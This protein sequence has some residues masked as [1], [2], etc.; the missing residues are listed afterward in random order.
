MRKYFWKPRFIKHL[1]I[2]SI[3]T[4]LIYFRNEIYLRYYVRCRLDQDAILKSESR[5][6]RNAPK[7]LEYNSK[8]KCRQNESIYLSQHDDY[9]KV[10]LISTNEITHHRVLFEY[11]IDKTKFEASI[12]TCDMYNSLRRGPHL[13]VLAYS[14]YGKK[15]S[16]YNFINELARLI[17]NYY[18]NWIMR[19]YYDRSIDMSII[20]EI[21][22]LMYDEKSKAEE[23][24]GN[25]V[26]LFLDNVDFCDIENIPYDTSKWWNASY[27]HGACYFYLMLFI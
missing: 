3:P 21:E 12:L 13:K 6:F 11:N 20:C 5:D 24:S 1:L 14:L 18:P 22:C 2:Y 4:L 7:F 15:Q 23:S 25:K 26:P 8:C 16:Y 27:M 19:I 9:Y 10:T 17:K